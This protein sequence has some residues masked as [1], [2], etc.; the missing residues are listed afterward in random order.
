MSIKRCN[1]CV[2][3]AGKYN[4]SRFVACVN[5]LYVAYICIY[6][7]SLY[8]ATYTN[9]FPRFVVI[10]AKRSGKSNRGFREVS[11]ENVHGSHSC[12]SLSTLCLVVGL[13]L[14]PMQTPRRP[15]VLL[16]CCRFLHLCAGKLI[17]FFIFIYAGIL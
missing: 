6:I 14:P 8:H 5:F 11:V 10:S 1:L 13:C 2:N 9:G 15:L 16:M 4:I 7:E 3:Q 12:V 17:L